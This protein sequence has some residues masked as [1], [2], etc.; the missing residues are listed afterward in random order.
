MNHESVLL[1]KREKVIDG[2]RYI[3][4]THYDETASET[5]EDKLV[6]VA[7]DRIKSQVMGD[8]NPSIVTCNPPPLE[9]SWD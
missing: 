3:V 1:Q 8:N 7:V 9:V 6:R 4:T 2:V 5:L